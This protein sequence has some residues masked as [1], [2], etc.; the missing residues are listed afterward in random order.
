MWQFLKLITISL[1]QLSTQPD[2][3]YFSKGESCCVSEPILP[4]LQSLYIYHR[5]RSLP[6]RGF[7]K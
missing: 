6:R 1:N 4:H 3:L 5:L 2:C 7:L